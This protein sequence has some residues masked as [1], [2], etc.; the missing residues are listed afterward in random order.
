MPGA[1]MTSHFHFLAAEWPAVHE[2]AVK[3]ELA[4]HADPRASCFYARRA[5]EIAVGW[6]YKHDSAL[7]LP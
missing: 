7:T 3:A 2:A 6:L 1:A 4:A 5:L